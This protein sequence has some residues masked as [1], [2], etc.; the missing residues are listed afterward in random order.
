MYNLIAKSNGYGT[1]DIGCGNTVPVQVRNVDCRSYG[2]N[3][4]EINLDWVVCN[5][6]EDYKAPRSNLRIKNVIFNVPATIVFW[7]DGTKTVVKAYA[8]DFDPEKGLAMAIAKKFF[9]NQGNYYN[10]FRKWLPKEEVETHHPK[11]SFAF[12]APSLV[13]IRNEIDEQ[14]TNALRLMIDDLLS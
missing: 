1:L 3:Q 13:A 4:H 2:R 5:T 11:T 8:D 9:G 7:T 10:E 6:A 12:R 14:Y